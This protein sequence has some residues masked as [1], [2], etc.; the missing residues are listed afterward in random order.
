MSPRRI[1]DRGTVADSTRTVLA[2]VGTGDSIAVNGSCLTVIA[3]APTWWD[4]ELSPETIDRTRLACFAAGDVVNL[5]RAVHAQDR[6]GG[7]LVQG[8]VDGRGDPGEAPSTLASGAPG[9][10]PYLR[11]LALRRR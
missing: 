10:F 6:L 11:S 7:H 5:E 4:A 8:H 9:A 1:A 2:D 3:F